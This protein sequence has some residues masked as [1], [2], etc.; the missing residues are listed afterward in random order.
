[1]GQG[2]VFNVG[3]GRPTSLLELLAALG[4]VFGVKPMPLFKEARAGDIRHSLADI[5]K[6][7]ATLGYEP[8][9]SLHQG[10]Q[11]LVDSVKR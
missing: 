1:M 6:I 3:T 9:H 2:E 5:G 4:D 8:K 11:E 7:R 10:L